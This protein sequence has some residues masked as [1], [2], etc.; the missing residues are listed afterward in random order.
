MPDS[1]NYQLKRASDNIWTDKSP[2]NIM[3]MLREIRA[4]QLETIRTLKAQQQAFILNEFQEPDYDGHRKDHN[5]LAAA[6]TLVESYKSEATK[7]II[8]AAVSFILGIMALGIFEY[9][10][11]GQP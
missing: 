11:R 8:S 1:N 7:N 10:K 2:E 3:E 5:K 9:F 4:T 6:N